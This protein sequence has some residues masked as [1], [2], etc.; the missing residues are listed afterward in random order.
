MK[1]SLIVFIIAVTL[2][3]SACSDLNNIAQ[4]QN[5]SAG[6]EPVEYVH[7][8]VVTHDFD[9]YIE[10]F[11]ELTLNDI[12]N[13]ANQR[14]HEINLPC[15]ER[16]AGLL[17]DSTAFTI[18]ED[19]FFN[20]EFEWLISRE[21][22]IYDTNVFFDIL[23]YC[24][25][26]YLFFGGD[27]VFLPVQ[28][29]IIETL[30]EKDVWK[31]IDFRDMIY[32]HIS[33]IIDDN[34]FVFD[35]RIVGTSSSFLYSEA[36]FYKTDNG[37]K[38]R[39]TGLYVKEIV[40][41]DMNDVFRLTVNECGEFFYI[42]VVYKTDDS[43]RSY[44]L[45]FIYEDGSE[46]TLQL[47][48]HIPRFLFNNEVSLKYER[49]F[50]IITLQRMGNPDSPYFGMQGVEVME[51]AR[52]FLSTASELRDNDVI[53]V[54]IR[55]NIGGQAILP[56]IWLYLLMDETIPN[57]FIRLKSQVEPVELSEFPLEIQDLIRRYES[58]RIN[59]PYID[60]TTQF[61]EMAESNV[62]PNR[63]NFESEDKVISNDRLIILLVD[64]WTSSAGER[65]VD[66][67]LSM[68]N[69]LIIGQNTAG[70]VLTSA[71][72][73]LFLPNS[74]TAF[75]MSLFMNVFDE[76]YFE[77]GRGI[78]PDVWVVGDALTATLAMLE[79][80]RIAQK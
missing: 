68:E 13:I 34:H 4:E 24:Y 2:G 59:S 64:R 32:N 63:I 5:E 23:R 11:D 27:E 8:E 78:A 17:Q 43:I 73:T 44:D 75:R 35:G 65:F 25:A 40:G 60:L 58:D 15:V 45:I 69:T 10:E 3:L 38:N 62:F 41:Y 70:V 33:G 22:A 21:D 29:K 46:E 1:K 74:N 67:I 61:S 79:S 47:S 9:E 49:G 51:G 76:D 54:D 16:V 12:I 36:S 26:P 6:Y 7:N 66:Q 80:H 56:Q 53:I 18:R 55:S 37:F 31:T 52:Y 50:P 39:D 42:P 14:R 19:I 20:G 28:E 57:N 48:K 71:C 72:D 77:E 30:N